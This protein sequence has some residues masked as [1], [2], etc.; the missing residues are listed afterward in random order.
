MAKNIRDLIKEY[1]DI[2]YMEDTSI[3]P[4]VCAVTLSNRMSGDPIWLMILGGSSSGKTEL[5]NAITGLS[6]VHS[7]SMLT[8]NT[9]LSGMKSKSVSNTSLLKRISPTSIFVMKDFTTILSMGRDDQQEI[10]SQLR[11]VYDGKMTKSTGHGEDL[12]WEGKITLIAGVTE[13]LHV[14]ENRFSGMGTRAI[15]YTLP[16]QD[17]VKT[18]KRSAHISK[19]IKSYR[20]HIKNEFKEYIEYMIPNIVSTDYEISEDVS[21]K[22]LR[23]CDFSSLARSPVERNFQGE[24]DLV[25]SSEMPMR[26]SNQLH[27]LGGVFMAMEA[28]ILLP[29]Y[30]RILYKLAFDSIPKGRRLVLRELCKYGDAKTKEVASSLGYESETARK[31]LEEINVLGICTRSSESGGGKGDIWTIKKEYKE[32]ISLYDGEPIIPITKEQIEVLREEG[33]EPE[34]ENINDEWGVFADKN[35]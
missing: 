1:T 9:L 10:M 13:K 26:M 3:I 20:E 21:D 25:L 33:I 19:G 28:G 4:L 12:K 15:N 18:A 24:I 11:E 16:L 6:F 34:E 5:L 35:E 8:P 27:S 32:I 22:L 29:E 30:E 17:R 23:V 7:I 14:M 2:Y 31:W